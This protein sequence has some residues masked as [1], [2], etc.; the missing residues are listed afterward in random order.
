VSVIRA[1]HVVCITIAACVLAISPLSA[2]S[3]GWTSWTSSTSGS[4]GSASG[5]LVAGGQTVN[6]TYA[7]EVDF[8][9]LNGTGF[10]YY[11]PAST[12]TSAIASNAPVTDM[13]GISG[14]TAAHTFSFSSP[15][16]NLTMAIVSL[17]QPGLGVSYN[18][19][20]PFTI[21]SQGPGI[22][23]GGCATC[24]SGSGTSVLTGTEG[25][26]VLEFAGTFTSLTFTVTN[27]EFWNGFTIGALGGTTPPA[28]PEPSSWGLSF[29]GLIGL[30]ALISRK[31]IVSRF[32]RLL[33]E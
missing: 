27:G 32:E 18:F 31:R 23:F 2:A 4:T 3:V 28:V 26:G 19:S 8:T 6:V 14:T 9:Q 15:V 29:L 13:I 25:D 5:S 12:Y 20:A 11:T 22:P 24:L 1:V 7:G 10:N 30:A 21:L 17:G 16:T 33:R